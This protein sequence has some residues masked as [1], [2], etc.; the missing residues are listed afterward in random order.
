[1]SNKVSAFISSLR[2]SFTKTDIKD[3]ARSLREASKEVTDTYKLLADTM[4]RRDF[5]SQTGK[6]YNAAFSKYVKGS[7]NQNI[8]IGLNGI[9][10]KIDSKIQAIEKILNEDQKSDIVREAISALEVNIIRFLETL[11]FVVVYGG[12]LATVLTICETNVSNK[13]D[14]LDSI[15]PAEA[16]YIANNGPQFWDALNAISPDARAIEHSFKSIPDIMLNKD[17]A[18]AMSTLVGRNKLDPMQMGFIPVQWNPFYHLNMAY[19]EWQADRFEKIVEDRNMVQFKIQ[20]Y[21]MA[22]SGTSNPQLDRKVQ[23]CQERL[24][25]L[26]HKIAKKVEEYGLDGNQYV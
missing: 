2:D 13:I 21:K 12:R 6:D 7:K 15:T 8:F 9:F 10:S 17:N 3:E 23:A 1:M 25:K 24:D 20:Q 26:N 19:S 22:A 18:D 5:V 14:E 11:N 16:E 4:G